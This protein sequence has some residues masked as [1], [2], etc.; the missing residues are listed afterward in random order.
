MVAFFMDKGVNLWEIDFSERFPPSLEET[1]PKPFAM[2]RRTLEAYEILGVDLEFPYQ[3]PDFLVEYFSVPFPR[4]SVVV[5]VS[6][7]EREK[8][9]RILQEIVALFEDRGVDICRIDFVWVAPNIVGP[10]PE[11]VGIGC[12]R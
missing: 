4:F 9:P 10:V 8:V 2:D 11:G 12:Q 7:F 3:D 5:T 1:L 6:D